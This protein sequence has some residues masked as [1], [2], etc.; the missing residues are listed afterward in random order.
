MQR[1][2]KG[3][4]TLLTH[5]FLNIN[6]AAE[7]CMVCTAGTV[8]VDLQWRR[9]LPNRQL[10]ATETLRGLC[11][12]NVGCKCDIWNMSFSKLSLKKKINTINK[13]QQHTCPVKLWSHQLH[14][15]VA[16]RLQQPNHTSVC[17]TFVRAVGFA[18]RTLTLTAASC[19]CSQPN[20][21]SNGF[22]WN[23]F[24]KHPWQSDT[25]PAQPPHHYHSNSSPV[26][27]LVWLQGYMTLVACPTPSR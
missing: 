26:C 2:S 7:G 8:Q 1:R 11:G 27:L 6:V 4:F 13:L 23:A 16:R 10:T 21:S 18:V 15:W 19:L 12:A 25:P 14:S 24:E 22:L 5:M 9:F 20:Q 3:F 17:R